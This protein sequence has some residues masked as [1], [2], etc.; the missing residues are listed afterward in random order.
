MVRFMLC[1]TF[2]HFLFYAGNALCTSGTTKHA[3]KGT[4]RHRHTEHQPVF[5]KTHNGPLE[6]AQ[7]Q[8]VGSE[9]PGL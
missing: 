1:I 9:T 6:G 3:K 8:K 5:H 4:T 2:T 7:K